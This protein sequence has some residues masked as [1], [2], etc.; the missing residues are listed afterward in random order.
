MNPHEVP[1]PLLGASDEQ[2]RVL[3]EP[4]SEALGDA[5]RQ[6]AA[7]GAEPRSG[8]RVAGYRL[9]R[10]LGEGGMAT[11]WLA[12]RADGQLKRQVAIKLPKASHASGVLAER[13]ARERD[14]LAALDHPHIA[15]LIDAGVAE[16]GQP[17]IVL[18]HV[19][20]VPITEYAA[21]RP[22]RDKLR[23]YLQV[24]D[25]VDHAH[26]HMTVHRD[27]K[28]SNIL[29]DAE[30][31]VKL[32]DFGIAKLLA[33]TADAP[34]L[35][36]EAVYLM[37]P[38][39]AAPEQVPGGGAVTT[40]TDVYSAGVVL[41]ELLTGRMPYGRADDSAAQSIQ[42]LTLTEP[43]LPGLGR[44]VD[45][46]LL[47]ALRKA[48]R[49][50]YA[51]V[52]HFAEDLRRLL[53]DRPV[54]ARR[55][56]WWQRLRLLLR[57]HRLASAAAVVGALLI[58]GAAALAWQQGRESE[59]QRARAETVRDFIYRMV[60]DAEPAQGR[61]E[62]TG[63]EMIDAAVARAGS[64]FASQPRLRGELLGEL[65]RVYFR[66]RQTEASV[67]TLQEAIGL[68]EASAESDDAALNRSRAA[69]A[70]ALL[71]SDGPRATALARQALDACTRP[72]TAC[73]EARALAHYALTAAESWLGHAPQALMHARAFV[74]ETER[75][76]GPD[77]LDL[78]SALEA[79]ATTAR[80]QGELREAAAAMQRAQAIAARRS[81]KAV[82]RAR[83][84]AVQSVID[85][86]L[87]HYG[88][89]RERLL[90][91]TRG[92]DAPTE[93]PLQWRLL[94]SAE[95]GLGRPEAAMAAARNALSDTARGAEGWVAVQAWGLAASLA[96]Q[97]DDGI[98]ALA[99]AHAGL[100]AAGFPP[101]SSSMLKLRRMQAEAL[102]RDGRADPVV[103]LRA[104]AAEHA[105]VPTPHRVEWGQALDALGCAEA[106]AGRADAARRL[107][108]TADERYASALPPEHPL[109]LR[110]A[111]LRDLLEGQAAAALAAWHRTLAADSPWRQRAVR[112]CRVV[113]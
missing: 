36:Q 18:E 98:A 62:V 96:G 10:P 113:I 63:R 44:D 66:L 94:A 71:R 11:V 109:R 15:R 23:L 89:A 83:L 58:G 72:G 47:K 31:Q 6:A 17:F 102:L 87:G 106:L 57:R 93:H 67:A 75:A 79:F 29:V 69:L 80:N 60:S 14:V 111:L 20:G 5:L 65:G 53:A 82:N 86:D 7:A 32:L 33:P 38:K 27:L 9:L 78:A 88:A 112:N 54:L 64:D 99:E 43:R 104:L 59:A 46:V 34:A 42:A 16:S 50:R 68:L 97:A 110:N 107:H 77:H 92:N 4:A 52:E 76:R 21:G 84:D 37:T 105:A 100:A 55:V 3:A 30:G 35:T 22:L 90:R 45:T 12:E 48:P 8:Q 81:M 26:R 24:L 2:T 91:L 95:I 39:Y 28:P 74:A 25:A 103:D 41:Y 19:A 70:E 56:P 85:I 49:D 101:A 40:A 108:A 1:S 13:F 73:A 61:S 51:S